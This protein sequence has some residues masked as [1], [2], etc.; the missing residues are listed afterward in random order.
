MLY[1]KVKIEKQDYRKKEVRI[2]VVASTYKRAVKLR[3]IKHGL[4]TESSN[5]SVKEKK[6]RIVIIDFISEFDLTFSIHSLL[7]SPFPPYT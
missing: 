6:I 4:L 5:N 3:L 7:A 2:T 1:T